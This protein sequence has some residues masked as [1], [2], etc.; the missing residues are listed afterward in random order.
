MATRQKT[1][2][3]RSRTTSRSPRGRRSE[4]VGKNGRAG[5]SSTTR[6]ERANSGSP[7]RGRK[8]EA[9]WEEAASREEEAA[10]DSGAQPGKGAVDEP[11][12]ALGVER[13]TEAEQT[14]S[15]EIPNARDRRR[16]NPERRGAQAA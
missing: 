11:E 4:K 12:R 8:A 7:M 5:G 16:S 15:R 13:D 2:K 10:G 9:D 14:T 6:R 1:Q 3:S